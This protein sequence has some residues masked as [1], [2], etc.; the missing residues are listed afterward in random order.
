MA[1]LES[2]RHAAD[3]LRALLPASRLP[4]YSQ[5]T[6]RQERACLY[7]R[8]M[9]SK[10]QL[11]RRNPSSMFFYGNLAMSRL[12]G[13]AAE[14]SIVSFPKSGRTWLD[15]LLVEAIRRHRGLEDDKSKTISELC[16][17]QS[18]LP[19][20]M[21]THA[22][23]GLQ[24][25]GVVWDE[26]EIEELSLRRFAPRRCVFLYRDPRDVLVSRYYHIKY[27]LGVEELTVEYLIDS[28]LIGLRKM[29]RFMNKWYDFTEQNP[30]STARV[31]YEDLRRNTTHEL[32]RI[33][34][35]VGF[36]ISAEAL[37]GASEACEFSAMR[38]K[39]KKSEYKNPRLTTGSPNPNS[40]K[41]RKGMIGEHREF[42]YPGQLSRINRIIVEELDDRFGYNT[43]TA[44][45]G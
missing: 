27:R 40:F 17:R 15:Q 45:E 8:V 13:P 30:E 18:E 11:F 44:S 26:D 6:R 1:P 10:L 32:H 37:S 4:V 14:V 31:R 41:V 3:I 35:L 2:F 23:S 21:F 20:I 38:E 22:G 34:A 43:P 7:R 28:P 29:L 33:F 24:E 42:F 39:E 16:R 9:R 12:F 36:A 25:D 5:R 19:S